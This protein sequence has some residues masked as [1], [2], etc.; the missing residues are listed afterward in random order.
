MPDFEVTVRVLLKDAGGGEQ[1]M[2][3]VRSLERK[4][5]GRFVQALIDTT[6]HAG[7]MADKV[8]AP[9]GGVAKHPQVP[10]V[11]SPATGPEAVRDADVQLGRR[12]ES[13]EVS[14]AIEEKLA[15]LHGLLEQTQAQVDAASKVRDAFARETARFEHDAGALFETFNKRLRTL[16]ESLDG[17]E[18]R[19]EALAVHERQLA[20]L[21]QRLDEFSHVFR[22]LAAQAEELT[23]RQASLAKVQ[24]QLSRETLH[25]AARNG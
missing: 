14:S 6:A 5:L 7:Q 19:L 13:Q 22:S 18:R 9:N 11:S 12:A 10:D 8:S 15:W 1:E 23:S 21:P 4:D 20:M 2:R 17:A 3:Y 16:Q 24:Q 25:A